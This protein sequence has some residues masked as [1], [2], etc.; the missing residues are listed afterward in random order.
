MNEIR[1][2][3]KDL[4]Q[5][6]DTKLLRMQ[7]YRQEAS[8]LASMANKR[9]ERIEKANLTDSPAYQQYVRDGKVRFGVRGKNYNQLQAEVAR[10]NQFL[11]SKTSTIRGINDVLKTLAENTGLHYKTL[12]DLKDKSRNFF[13]LANRVEDYLRSV[14]DRASAIGYARIWEAVNTFV[15]RQEL[16][17]SQA[18]DDIDDYVLK[19]IKIIDEFDDKIHFTHKTD[20]VSF[21]GWF[22]FPK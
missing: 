2:R 11:N 18:D 8:R 10:M 19:I 13:R 20:M 12:D 15:Q 5:K 4:K 7:K 21:E 9:I 17:L 14:E 22:K 1:I 16:D 6:V 3:N